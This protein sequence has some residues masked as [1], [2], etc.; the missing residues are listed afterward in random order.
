MGL[1][2]RFYDPKEG[3]VLLNQRP[4]TEYNLQSYRKRLVGDKQ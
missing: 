2:L 1:M 4:L 3:L